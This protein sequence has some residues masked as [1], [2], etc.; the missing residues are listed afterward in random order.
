MVLTFSEFEH[1][2]DRAAAALHDNGFRPG[3]RLA[4]LSHNCWEYAALT[5][6]SA[7][8]GLILVPINFMLTAE[9]VAFILPHPGPR[10]HRRG[11]ALA[12]VA[13]AHVERGDAAALGRSGPPPAR[14][15]P[16]ARWCADRRRRP[17]VL[18]ARRRPAQLMYTS[19]TESRPKGAM[20]TSR[21]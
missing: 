10:P 17:A 14:L 5:M 4:L 1:L 16:L 19:G 6:A 8:L 11:I 12:D 3:D 2:V 9:D 18:A 21:T 15:G 13:S 20:P 7:K